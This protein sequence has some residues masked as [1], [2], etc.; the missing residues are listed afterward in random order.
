MKAIWRLVSIQ[1]IFCD[2]HF[3]HFFVLS[4]LGRFGYTKNLKDQFDYKYKDQYEVTY[5]CFG[6]YDPK[7]K[8]HITYYVS[9]RL[10]YRD[11]TYSTAIKTNPL[12][13][14]TRRHL[15]AVMRTWS[16]VPFPEDCHLHRDDLNTEGSHN[17][18]VTAKPPPDF[19]TGVPETCRKYVKPCHCA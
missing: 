13:P 14:G 18:I 1:N 19:D 12:E 9:D 3:Y 7:N 2:S 6:H 10:G 11:A 17:V 5:G 15:P 4:S 16:E 8:L